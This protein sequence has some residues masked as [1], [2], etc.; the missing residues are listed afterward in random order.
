MAMIPE[1]VRIAAA[2]AQSSIPAAA[3]ATASSTA[4]PAAVNA[5]SETYFVDQTTR[6]I[7]GTIRSTC[8]KRAI[9]APA[10]VATPFP[11]LNPMNGDQQCPAT[12]ATAA[13]ATQA[14]SN[15]TAVAKT[16]GSTPFR[17]SS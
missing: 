15:P 9:A 12:A 14:A 16:T 11:P 17:M 7:A 2:D 6:A 3:Y 8:G 13:V 4:S 5:P 1:M 10:P